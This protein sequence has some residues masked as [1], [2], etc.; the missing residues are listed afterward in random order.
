MAH[1][2]VLLE[3]VLTEAGDADVVHFHI[4][5]LHYA[6][7]RRYLPRSLTTLH[8]RLDLPDLIPLYETFPDVNVVSISHHQRTPLPQLHWLGTVYHG[9]PSMLL[10]VGNGDGGYLAFLGRISPEKRVD[11]AITIAR[12]TGRRLKIA[13]KVDA[14][15]RDYFEQE[16]RHLLDD[17]L[18]E[19]I[20]EIGDADKA[21]FLGQATALLF[22]IDWPEPFGLVMIEALACG[23]PVIAYR[24][25]AVP[26]LLTDG[27]CGFVVDND[28]EAVR[29]VRQLS[30]ISRA[31]CRRLFERRFTAQRMAN[32]YVALYRDLANG[33]VVERAS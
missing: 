25:G 15:D 14:Q 31:A 9:L 19:F 18:I 8:G 26:E 30:W 22:P 32:D 28:D 3:K 2:M 29:A 12:R 13:A 27:E 4:D 5:Y 11:R 6:F 21:A 7:S 20:G 33:D 17:P 1:H 24:R 10:P 16:I 23:T